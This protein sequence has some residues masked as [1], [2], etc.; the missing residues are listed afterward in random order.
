MTTQQEIATQFTNVTRPLFERVQRA[1]ALL[2]MVQFRL[3]NGA[4]MSKL[5]SEDLGIIVDL[6]AESMPHH[7]DEVDGPLDG[8]YFQVAAAL[9]TE[10]TRSNRLEDILNA[11][12]MVA[13]LDSTCEE[14]TTAA[15]TVF[16]IA[17]A[18]G[19]YEPDWRTLRE[20]LETRGL[21]VEVTPF[22]NVCSV[23][24]VTTKAGQKAKKKTAR[25]IA[26]LI[27]ATN[28]ETALSQQV[29]SMKAA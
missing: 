3:Q 10:A 6:C 16:D 5:E 26:K 25:V 18:D 15:K 1:G 22:G 19:A 14:L 24:N 29:P 9:K 8:V 12:Q 13:R 17:Q 28:Q 4:E 23:L 20:T 21:L 11:M 2:R 7:Y 27:E